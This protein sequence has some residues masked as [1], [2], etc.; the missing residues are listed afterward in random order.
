MEE[1][2]RRG[3]EL[4]DPNGSSRELE[5]EFL[6]RIVVEPIPS[7]AGAVFASFDVATESRAADVLAPQVIEGNEVLEL[8]AGSARPLRRDPVELLAEL[9]VVEKRDE[10]QGL[11]AKRLLNY[12]ALQRAACGA[13]KWLP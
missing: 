2:P 9:L 6:Q 1:K 4:P 7:V 10:L 11:E 13:W 8:R 5:A 12:A 3:D